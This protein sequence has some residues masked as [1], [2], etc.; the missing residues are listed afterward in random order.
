LYQSVG[1]F[2]FKSF[3]INSSVAR[4]VVSNTV[5]HARTWCPPTA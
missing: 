2:M 1:A 3:E 5:L 4:L